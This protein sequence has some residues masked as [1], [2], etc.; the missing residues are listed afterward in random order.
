VLGKIQEDKVANRPIYL[1]LG[2]TVAG[3]RDLGLW[4]GD[5]GEG[6]KDCFEC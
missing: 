4:A 6:A 2:V 5:G 1:V 3:E